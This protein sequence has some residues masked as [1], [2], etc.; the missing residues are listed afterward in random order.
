MSI[1]GSHLRTLA[2]RTHPTS[3]AAPGEWPV[4]GGTAEP[5]PPIHL[6]TIDLFVLPIVDL[7]QTCTFLPLPHEQALS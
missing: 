4:G 3:R 5:S 6:A 7:Q 1:T 2:R